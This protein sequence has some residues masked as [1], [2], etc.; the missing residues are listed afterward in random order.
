MIKESFKNHLYFV[1]KL[2]NLTYLLKLI[3]YFEDYVCI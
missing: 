1:K 3:E 2:S